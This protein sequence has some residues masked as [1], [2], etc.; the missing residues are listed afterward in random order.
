MRLNDFRV[1]LVLES[2]FYKTFLKLMISS[3]KSSRVVFLTIIF[4][5]NEFF[6]YKNYNKL[7]FY[8]RKLIKQKF[9]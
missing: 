7:L 3:R 4:I 5:N 2:I 1:K 9:K 6:I 8:Y